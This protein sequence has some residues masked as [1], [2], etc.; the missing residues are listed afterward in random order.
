MLSLKGVAQSNILSLIRGGS[1][2]FKFIQTVQEIQRLGG[3]DVASMFPR[4]S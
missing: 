4:Y 1:I 2:L 3:L